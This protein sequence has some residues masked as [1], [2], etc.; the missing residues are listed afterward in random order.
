DPCRQNLEQKTKV[1]VEFTKA[2]SY[3]TLFQVVGSRNY[4]DQASLSLDAALEYAKPYGEFKGK[5]VLYL[6]RSIVA[7][8][9]NDF[10][11]AQ[12][13]I[14]AALKLNPNYGRAYI[15]R[16]NMYYTEATALLTRGTPLRQDETLTF[17]EDLEQARIEYLEAARQWEK[18]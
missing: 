16:G 1:V 2:L 4:L 12:E 6:F 11:A 18:P 15:A 17:Q 9:K 13:A 5:E 8:A 10:Q 3:L 14:D 7:R